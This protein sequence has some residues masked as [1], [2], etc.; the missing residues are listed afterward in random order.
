M[1]TVPMR[2]SN[3]SVMAASSFLG[4]DRLAAAAARERAMRGHANGFLAL[5][6]LVM[7]FILEACRRCRS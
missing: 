5:G 7:S 2:L 4:R 3:P 1:V 6:G